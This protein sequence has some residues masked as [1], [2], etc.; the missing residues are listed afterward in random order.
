MGSNPVLIPEN[1]IISNFMVLFPLY[2]FI[3]AHS[4]NPNPLRFPA[5]SALWS[6]NTYR[7]PDFPEYVERGSYFDYL[8]SLYDQSSEQ[9][10]RPDVELEILVFNLSDP[11]AHHANHE[12]W[13]DL[14]RLLI[15]HNQDE[16]QDYEDY[17]ESPAYQKQSR[18][19]QL[20]FTGTLLVHMRN[21]HRG[22][23]DPR[24]QYVWR[25][26]NGLFT[27]K[28]IQERTYFTNQNFSIVLEALRIKLELKHTNCDKL[29]GALLGAYLASTDTHHQNLY[30]LLQLAAQFEQQRPGHWLLINRRCLQKLKK[31]SRR[32][33]Y[34]TEVDKVPMQLLCIED[35]K[36]HYS[37]FWL[38]PTAILEQVNAFAEQTLDVIKRILSSNLSSESSDAEIVSRITREIVFHNAVNCVEYEGQVD[39]F[40]NDPL[41]TR[42]L[43]RSNDL[44]YLSSLVAE[45]CRFDPRVD[46]YHGLVKF[47]L[48]R[49]AGHITNPAILKRLPIALVVSILNSG[50]TDV[51]PI[52]RFF[53]RMDQLNETLDSH[54]QFSTTFLMEHVIPLVFLYENFGLRIFDRMTNLLQPTEQKLHRTLSRIRVLPQRYIRLLNTLLTWC[55][56]QQSSR[57]FEILELMVNVELILLESNMQSIDP[58]SIIDEYEQALTHCNQNLDPYLNAI[59]KIAS[60]VYQVKLG[61]KNFSLATEK[62]TESLK[63]LPLL[64]VG[65]AKLNDEYREVFD[66]MIRV[67]F[68]DGG[69]FDLLISDEEQ[70][71]T[72]GASIG[73]HNMD[74]VRVLYEYDINADTVRQYGHKTTFS[75][76]ERGNPDYCQLCVSIWNHIQALDQYLTVH[77]L[78]VF[79]Q[80][81]RKIV[82]VSEDVYE[83]ARLQ[84]PCFEQAFEK[85]LPELKKEQA[86]RI[87]EHATHIVQ[88]ATRLFSGLKGSNRNFKMNLFSERTF[89]VKN[90]DKRDKRTLALGRYF[91]CCL[92]P[93]REWFEAMIQRRL[94]L[95]MPIHVVVDRNDK[96]VAGI[97]LFFA[98]RGN[99]IVLVANFVEAHPKIA[100]K[101]ALCAKIVD[102]LLTYT[103]QYAADLGA[104]EFLLRPLS[105]G[106]IPD[107]KEKFPLVRATLKKVG[108]C[109]GKS[110]YYLEALEENFFYSYPLPQKLDD[111]HQLGIGL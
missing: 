1:R 63:L 65:R 58:E 37:G 86:P 13:N 41:K 35:C 6:H 104:S 44:A 68:T 49:K 53:R 96:P 69:R 7:M 30:Q 43:V 19:E 38:R 88:D 8:K 52:E 78:K 25:H 105:Y 3:I 21:F 77:P 60:K 29:L 99:E 102:E 42:G 31:T 10:P 66:R 84:H 27:E 109:Y 34:E 71:D 55:N 82:T 80:D 74:I 100:E 93:A 23:T 97:W 79:I 36:T 26:W 14:M 103:A 75:T 83:S 87:T 72:I 20:K 90:W 48:T 76:M 51:S 15:A 46:R 94:D 89:T 50:C 54:L 95:A 17:F 39:T 92:D 45:D 11:N 24:F 33:F 56:A 108:G 5:L 57:W 81:V 4:M 98:F 73:R 110:D 9:V 18:N 12:C 85:A 16:L 64:L 91:D 106:N 61:V 2:C 67:D 28:K 40:I 101:S 107:F 62:V 47:S 32:I 70:A 111:H 22:N 59:I